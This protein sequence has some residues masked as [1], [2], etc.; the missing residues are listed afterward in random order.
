MAFHPDSLTASTFRGFADRLQR[1]AKAQPPGSDARLAWCQE[2]AARMLGFRDLHAAQT[3]LNGNREGGQGAPGVDV[4]GDVHWKLPALPGGGCWQVDLRTPAG[5]PGGSLDDALVVTGAQLRERVLFIGRETVRQK[6]LQRLIETVAGLERP[7]LV[8]Q[9][10]AA[11]PLDVSMPVATTDSHSAVDDFLS[12]R[13]A[14]EIIDLFARAVPPGEGDGGMWKGRAVALFSAVVRVRVWLRDHGGRLNLQILRDTLT[15][16]A[17]EALSE[18]AEVPESM[19][20]GMRAYLESIPGWLGGRDDELAA[21]QHDYLQMQVTGAL[22]RLDTTAGPGNDS[23]VLKVDVWS[24]REQGRDRVLDRWI[25]HGRNG[26]LILD[27]LEPD[28]WLWR[29]IPQIAGR[30]EAGGHGCVLGLGCPSDLPDGA[31]RERVLDRFGGCLVADNGSGMQIGD[32]G[33]LL[34]R[35][36]RAGG[37]G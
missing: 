35:F 34:R 26:V 4:G 6:A 16:Q 11:L 8:M 21:E 10:P 27:G 2:A 32:A 22:G 14:D 36:R 33:T 12:N 3:A 37:D 28:S 9:G 5:S 20:A 15:L 13:T 18:N 31:L 7:L 30:L 24:D 1:F 25:E 29:R 17:V 19:R 23:S